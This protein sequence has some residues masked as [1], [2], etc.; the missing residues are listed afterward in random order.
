MNPDAT[1]E[2]MDSI[3]R[4]V[5]K[6]L[7]MAEDG[8]G[9]PEEAA[10]A[11]SMAAKIMRKFQLEHSDVIISDLNKG[12]GM[13]EDW[14][15]GT[16]STDG[17]AKTVPGWVQWMAVALAKVHDLRV[18]LTRVPAGQPKAGDGCIRFAGFSSDVQVAS[19]T[20][21]YLVSTVNR[22][23]DGYRKTVDYQLKGRGSSAAFRDGAAS[24]IC[25]LILASKAEEVQTS[26][27]T[28][29]V[30]AKSRAVAERFGENKFKD[31]KKNIRDTA[32][33][34]AGYQAGQKVDVNRRG[35]GSSAPSADAALRIGR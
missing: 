18:S 12:E 26:T 34:G 8:R 20:L 33:Y 29:L 5:K 21:S 30:V 10:A 2:N 24:G 1:P 31:S 23:T 3:L 7:A 16:S 4:R 13:S 35:L 22:L 28:A 25:K 15:V 6:L 17:R 19:W 32:A 11:A 27:G 9:N 14:I